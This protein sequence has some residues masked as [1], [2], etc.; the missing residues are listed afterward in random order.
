MS[1]MR[2]RTTIFLLFL[3]LTGGLVLAGCQAAAEPAPVTKKATPQ[4]KPVAANPIVNT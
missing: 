1:E 3:A 4:I 2:H